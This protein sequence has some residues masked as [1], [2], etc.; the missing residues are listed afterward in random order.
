MV[1][2]KCTGDKISCERIY[3]DQASALVQIGLLDAADLP[4]AGVDTARKV[5]DPSQPSNE[6]IR[7]VQRRRGDEDNGR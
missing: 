2:V 5:V 4:A 1:V 6:L 3:W 7:R